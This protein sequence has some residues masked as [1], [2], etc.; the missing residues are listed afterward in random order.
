MDA[1][2]GHNS[3]DVGS[4]KASDKQAGSTTSLTAARM[5]EMV[6]LHRRWLLSDGREGYKAVFIGKDLSAHRELLQDADLT[7]AEFAQANLSNMSL[8]G[9]KFLGCQ[10]QQANLT[11]VDAL[12]ADFGGANLANAA[13]VGAK[14]QRANFRGTNLLHADLQRAV[15]DAADLSRANLRMAN[16]R[17]TS[18]KDAILSHADLS[19]PPVPADNRVITRVL[20]SIAV[21]IGWCQ[22]PFVL[23]ACECIGARFAPYTQDHWSL[24]RRKY[25]GSR[26]AILV[27]FTMLAFLPLIAQAMLWSTIAKVEAPLRHLVE[28]ERA[29]LVKLKALLVRV[30]QQ[31]ERAEA[32]PESLRR[33]LDE[34]I[35]PLTTADELQ[36]RQIDASLESGETHRSR[37]TR[38]TVAGTLLGYG[39]GTWQV[40]FTVL[41]LFYHVL[42]ALL[43]FFVAAL[44]DEEERTGVSPALARY[45]KWWILHV[46]TTV[47]LMP[48][49]YGSLA[50]RLL[51]ILFFTQV[52]VPW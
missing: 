16:M 23:D 3:D 52:Y 9:T 2:Q 4:E 25:T 29:S 28:Q 46:F 26:Y 22:P 37:F 30:R 21:E 50:W 40:S 15:L 20:R 19:V 39:Q 45:S 48:L 18:L 13:L 14:C 35:A 51:S 42:R 11:G 34:A 49:A 33:Q 27:A 43:T 6:E 24:L 17:R 10:M 47:F 1:V 8:T 36:K 41:L 12:M 31:A 7:R 32:L 5:R 38:R 44:R